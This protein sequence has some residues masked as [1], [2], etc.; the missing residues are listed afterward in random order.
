MNKRDEVR[1]RDMLDTALNGVQFIQGKSRQ[2]LA[3]N[4]MLAYALMRAI[5]VVGEAAAQL[6]PEIRNAY[7]QIAWK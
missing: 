1:L 6:T 7:P 3:D 2:D 4:V 5:E